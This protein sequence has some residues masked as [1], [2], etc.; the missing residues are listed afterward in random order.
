MPKLIRMH[1]AY[2]PL[3]SGAGGV[4][5]KHRSTTSTADNPPGPPCQGGEE[6][7]HRICHA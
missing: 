3:I 6:H 2:Y 4:G 1:P 5:V 7:V